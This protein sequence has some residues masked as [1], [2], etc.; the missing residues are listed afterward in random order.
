MVIYEIV[1]SVNGKKYIGKH[2][3]DVS[4]GRWYG[5]K[6]DLKKNK[7]R[8][9]HLQHAWNKYGA[10][11]FQFNTIESGILTI[12][13][14]NLREVFYIKKYK[15]MDDRFGYNLREGGTGGRFSEESKRK[16]SKSLSEGH[17]TGRIVVWN[18]GIPRTEEEKLNMSKSILR[19]FKNGRITWNVGKPWSKKMKK[20]ISESLVGKKLSIEEQDKRVNRE[21]PILIDTAGNEHE[22]VNLS[23]FCKENGFKRYG[24]WAVINGYQKSCYGGWRIK[25]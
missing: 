21:Y 3:G 17:R 16:L 18:R 15:T 24:F 23:R 19:G 13:E 1:N 10:S 12:D 22:I 4:D 11:N 7:H 6:S 8:N 25:Q 5:H 14:L 9:C 20:K 2:V